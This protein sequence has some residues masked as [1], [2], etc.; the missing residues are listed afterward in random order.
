MT[1]LKGGVVQNGG[2]VGHTVTTNGLNPAALAQADGPIP[3]YTMD[4]DHLLRYSTYARGTHPLVGAKMVL[5]DGPG[6]PRTPIPPEAFFHADK[7]RR[8]HSEETIALTLANHKGGVGKM[9]SALNLA[10]GLAFR[11]AAPPTQDGRALTGVLHYSV[12]RRGDVCIPLV[13]A[14]R[15]KAHGECA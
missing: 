15:V 5:K 6:Y 4:G 14:G 11:Y 8:R 9:T 13:H 3:I 2:E 7:V 10:F 1:T 12:A